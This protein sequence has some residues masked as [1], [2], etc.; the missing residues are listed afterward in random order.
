MEC[1]LHKGETFTFFCFTD[2]C[3]LC[4]E[5]MNQHPINHNFKTFSAGFPEVLEKNEPVTFHEAAISKTHDN[6]KQKI[7]N[8]IESNIKSK[9]EIQKQYNKVKEIKKEL[10][11]KMLCTMNAAQLDEKVFL[12]NHLLH[13]EEALAKKS[14][15]TYNKMRRPFELKNNNAFI[16]FVR[17]KEAKKNLIE[18]SKCQKVK[19]VVEEEL[20]KMKNLLTEWNAKLRKIQDATEEYKEK[21]NS[22]F[23]G[24]EP[25]IPETGA[26]PPPQNL[27]NN[28]HQKAH[29]PEKKIIYQKEPEPKKKIIPQ[30]EHETE[31]KN[32]PHTVPEPEKKIVPEPEKK[33]IPHNLPEQE[34][35]S[36]P[37]KIP[38]EEK[39]IFYEEIIESKAVLHPEP[40]NKANDTFHM[41]KI[42]SQK[43]ANPSIRNT[44][45][46]LDT[47]TSNIF[48]YDVITRKHKRMQVKQS[49]D[50][51][52][53]SLAYN[54]FILVC[55][56]QNKEQ[57]CYIN[58]TYEIDYT[59]GSCSIVS[60]GDL[61]R[62]RVDHCLVKAEDFIFCAGG[63]SG[64]FLN[65]VEVYAGGNWKQAKPICV[66]CG[67][68][69]GIF[70]QSLRIIYL[71]G[72]RNIKSYLEVIQFFK[73]D[74][75]DPHYEGSVFPQDDW[76]ILEVFL[77]NRCTYVTAVEYNEK[78]L[79][80][81][82]GLKDSCLQFDP[83]QKNFENEELKL[84]ADPVRFKR[85][86]SFSLDKG[87]FAIAYQSYKMF[88]YCDNNWEILTSEEWAGE[89]IVGDTSTTILA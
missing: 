44:L 13:V 3:M 83:L 12:L 1:P 14:N 63:Y 19:A 16:N 25:I 9:E 84:P 26:K 69:S 36:T 82:G 58:S 22:I 20:I 65:S 47:S 73:L 30:K 34:K 4:P 75:V 42:Q 80:M 48:I 50:L 43:I 72:G 24:N 2:D 55:G 23:E 52:C 59:L 60:K 29:E 10:K 28:K 35:K 71:F 67:N 41:E 40:E 11:K 89:K 45:A 6:I 64:S 86:A 70:M 7:S 27:P 38:K 77:P 33:I 76:D 78:I 51:N 18:L 56:G 88:C 81:G 66:Q 79:I 87:I 57:N 8:L 17:L 21:L 62:G 61:I 37:E 32:A 85:N 68:I 39:K 54:N 15:D 49:F 74:S 5:C 53:E 31:K 46:F